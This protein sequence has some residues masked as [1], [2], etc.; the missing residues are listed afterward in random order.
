MAGGRRAIAP[1]LRFGAAVAAYMARHGREFDVVHC[2]N[3]PHF[4]LI[5]ARLGLLPHRGVRLYGD[6]H[7]VW[8]RSSWQEYLGRRAGDVGY[9]IQRLAVHA[10][11]SNVSFSHLHG[12][13]LRHEG[14]SEPIVVLPEFLPDGAPTPNGHH[15]RERLVVFLGRLIPEKQ[16]ELLPDVIAALRRHDPSWRGIVFGDGPARGD[17]AERA[18]ELHLNGALRLPGIAPRDQVEDALCRAAVLVL[19]S[20]REGFGIVV[21]EAAALGTP[22][23]LV[24]AP[25]NAAVELVEEDVNGRVVAEPDPDAIAAAILRLTAVPNIHERTKDWWAQAQRR[26]DPAETIRLLEAEW[27]RRG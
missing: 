11:H 26:Y 24:R 4:A 19:P 22:T 18:R 1:T 6:W 12:D 16:A 3:F 8:R 2:A 27:E 7:E 23:V 25:D 5:G 15:P 9:G 21:L 17:V 20:K 14:R 13:R 10:A